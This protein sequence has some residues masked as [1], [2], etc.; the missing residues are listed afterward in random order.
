MKAVSF[1]HLFVQLALE[2]NSFYD[3]ER[4]GLLIEDA[5]GNNIVQCLTCSSDS[6]YYDEEHHQLVDTTFLAVLIQLRRLG[7]LVQEDI[8]Q[9][10][11]VHQLCHG[12]YLAE[13]RFR[14]MTEWCPSAL[15][16]TNV[17]KNE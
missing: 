4:S 5:D 3:G 9:Y 7:Y 15:L 6:S 17:Y 16:R 14:F 12:T 13:Q 10:D 8:Q 2:F 11:L 1:L